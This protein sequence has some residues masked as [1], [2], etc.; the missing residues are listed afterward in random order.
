MADEAILL[1]FDIG[2]T[3]NKCSLFSSDGRA[4]ASV[5]VP[6][7]T[8]YSRSGWAEQE[9]ED[10]WRSTVTGTKL[11]GERYPEYLKRVVGI[12]LSGHMNGMLPVDGAGQPLYREIIHADSR[13]EPQCR[14]IRERIAED[15]FFRITGNRIDSHLSLPKVLWFRDEHPDLYRKTAAV[16]QSKDFTAGRLVGRM[17]TTDLSDASLTCALDISRKSW[18]SEL[19]QELGLDMEKFPVILLSQDIVGG[20]CTEAAHL[21]GLPEG[22]PVTAG[23]GDAACSTRGAGVNDYTTAMNCIGSSSWISLLAAEPLLDAG[24]RIQNFYD[25]DGESC[26]IC[27]TVQSAGSVVDWMADA[28]VA[29]VEMADAL[30]KP[31]GLSKG[32]GS[33]EGHDSRH[34]RYFEKL[35]S[36]S[37]PGANGLVLLPY[38]MGERTP[39]WNQDLKGSFIGLSP[40]HTRRDMAR[41]VYEGVGFALRDVLQVFVE[42]NLSV[43]ELVLTGGGALSRFW[44]Q[45][46]SSLFGRPIKVP[47]Y[48]KQATSL[49]AATAAMVGLGMYRSYAEAAGTM[50][51]PVLFSPDAADT[52]AYDTLFTRYQAIYPAYAALC[53]ALNK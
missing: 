44:N 20:L 42:N 14:Y 25:I 5:T 53:A 46:L 29:D 31:E 26:T 21:L 3:G 11:L 32:P 27:G 34:Y 9:P 6:Y 52:Q 23:G 28:L 22:L 35:A 39:H 49:G 37:P 4:L 17:G 38:F 15:E 33:R 19:L 2:T 51:Y 18:S 40:G 7:P 45:L 47:S 48:P 13:S 8:F 1:T 50:Q 43:N 30:K 36:Q 10:Y 12:G 24:M 16:L 41:A